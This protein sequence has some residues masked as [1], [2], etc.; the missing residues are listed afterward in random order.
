[1]TD[2]DLVRQL[3]LR[4]AR[5][6]ADAG[7]S[8]G[9]NPAQSMALEYLAR[10]NKFSRQPSHVAE[11]MGSTRGT[12]SQTLKVLREKGLIDEV[13]S[14][15]DR[16]ALSYKLTQSGQKSLA[17]SSSLRNSLKELSPLEIDRLGK[18]LQA[19]LDTALEANG[20]KPFGVCKTCR[21]FAPYTKGGFCNLLSTPIDQSEAEKICVEN[22]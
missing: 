14:K 7:R 6:D 13:R 21:H 2:T 5:L 16:R 8:G 15:T 19:V 20:Q 11:F 17:Q 9:L 12:V 1:M 4:L 10:A 18:S 22:L 3:V